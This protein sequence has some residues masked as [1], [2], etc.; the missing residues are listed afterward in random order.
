MK[1]I[2]EMIRR[3]EYR[4]DTTAARFARRHPCIA[5]FLHFYRGTVFY[6]GSGLCFGLR[7]GVPYSLGQRM[8][9]KIKLFLFLFLA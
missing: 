3:A 8:D 9:V 7:C 1:Y 6:S 5:L 2:R 4:F